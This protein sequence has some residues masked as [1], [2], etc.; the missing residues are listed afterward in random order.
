M[1]L[2]VGASEI[3]ALALTEGELKHIFLGIY[4]LNARTSLILGRREYCEMIWTSGA[5]VEDY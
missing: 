4:N 1:L 3:I 2:V 5:G